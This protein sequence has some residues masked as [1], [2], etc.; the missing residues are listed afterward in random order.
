MGKV[1]GYS[2][3]ITLLPSVTPLALHLNS[4]F[5]VYT[6]LIKGNALEILKL[7]VQQ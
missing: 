5:P 1:I 3:F 7:Y 4:L 6:A 2:H